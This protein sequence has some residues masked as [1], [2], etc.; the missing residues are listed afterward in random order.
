MVITDPPRG[1]VTL[2]HKLPCVNV[3]IRG[4]GDHLPKVD[5][6]IKRTKETY[7]SVK[8]GLVHKLP[9]LTMKYL[10]TYCILRLDFRRNKAL[11]SNMCPGVSFTANKANYNYKR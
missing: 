3:E 11:N 7:R 9:V 1:L 4:A 6:K 2:Q 5:A 8:C 10:V